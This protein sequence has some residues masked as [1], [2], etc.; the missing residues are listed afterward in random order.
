MRPP[1]DAIQ[2]ADVSARPFLAISL[3]HDAGAHLTCNRIDRANAFMFLV[4]QSPN[5][6]VLLE[7]GFRTL[8]NFVE[9]CDHHSLTYSDLDEAIRTINELSH[10]SAEVKLP[11]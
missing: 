2:K 3:K 9:A 8:A 6:T 4:K 7:R 11:A 5:Y 10:T 1:L